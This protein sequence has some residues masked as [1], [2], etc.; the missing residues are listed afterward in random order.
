MIPTV[1]LRE[2]LR[3]PELLGG[4]ISGESW[5][6][7]R[8]LLLACL[9][10]ELTDDEHE[11]F[12]KLTGGR[13]EP[14]QLIE[15]FVGVI[16]RRGGKSYAIAVL[17]AYI[18]GL[19]RHP[20]LVRGERGI[21]LVIAPDQ[22]QAQICLDYITAIFE[23]SPILRQLIEGH[24]QST[25]RLTNGIDI[26]VRASDFRRLRGPT[27]ICSSPTK[28]HFISPKIVQTRIARF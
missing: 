28:W 6:G 3:E 1:S 12:R 16:G 23:A 22:R 18:A 9:G 11:L 19:C 17:A 4:T 7:W 24:T 10:E 27:Y 8:C 5:V 14:G 2:A 20:A 25:L 13:A 15:E 26:E 21:V